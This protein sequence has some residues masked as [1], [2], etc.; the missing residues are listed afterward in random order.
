MAVLLR[1]LWPALAQVLDDFV[2]SKHRALQRRSFHRLRRQHVLEEDEVSV[3]PIDIVPGRVKPRPNG[4][5][6]LLRRRL[7]GHHITKNSIELPPPLPGR[8][9]DRHLAERAS[10]KNR[11]PCVMQT[12]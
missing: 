11:Q 6:L 2:R 12:S 3:P 7:R 9:V 8:S 1:G 4:A 5:K 10:S